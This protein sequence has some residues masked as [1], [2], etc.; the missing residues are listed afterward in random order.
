MK[1]NK[2]VLVIFIFFPF[3]SMLSACVDGTDAPARS[4]ELYYDALV[5][6]EEARFLQYSCSNWE[7]QALLEFDS[8]RN[9]KTDL[10]DSKC[11]TDHLED[12]IAYVTCQ[13]YI[14][15]SY[16]GENREFSLSDKTFNVVMEGGEWRVC[17][18]ENN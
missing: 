11:Q 1:I 6:K 13:G 3:L 18:Y 8:F 10:V 7:I 2:I 5:K 17:G 16:D 14:N 12:D 4:V 15:A 9:V